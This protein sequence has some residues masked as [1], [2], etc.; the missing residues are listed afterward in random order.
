MKLF[1]TS[2]GCFHFN[3]EYLTVYP[4]PEKLE[5]TGVDKVVKGLDDIR[6]VLATSKVNEIKIYDRNGALKHVL[7]GDDVKTFI[8]TLLTPDISHED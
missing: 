4:I 2:V 3:P 8:K 7:H 6:K 5:G 1:V